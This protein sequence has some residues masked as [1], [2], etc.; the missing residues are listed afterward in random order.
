MNQ[1]ESF[2]KI[3]KSVIVAAWMFA[4]SSLSAD[5]LELVSGTLLEG[6]FVGYSNKMVMFDTGG[7]I[8][9]LPRSEVVAI[10][11]TEGVATRQAVMA[12]PNTVTLPVGTRLVVRMAD[13]V[14][15]K[16]HGAGHRFR[17][18]LE[19]ALVID[20]VTVAP[21]G[22]FLYGQILDAQS[23]RRIAGSA[24]LAL[25]FTDI[26]LD[27]QLYPIETA[28]L[29]AQ[30]SNEAGRTVGRTARAAAVGGL[31]GGS[32]GAKTGAKV[33]VGASILTSGASISV[34]A[35]T[36]VETEIRTPVDLPI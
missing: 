35:G 2:M 5:T 34:P 15:T 20:G 26:M 4:F 18:Q 7:D 30:T 21:R 11:L 19:S 1:Q 9:A 24:E 33:G 28:V 29:S 14:D 12:S 32:S 6:N 17:G 16:Q 25:V 31:I 13:S 10:F 22:A 3:Y 8:Q 23:A 27:D 36:M